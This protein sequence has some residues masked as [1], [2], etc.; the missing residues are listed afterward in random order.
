VYLGFYSLYKTLRHITTYLCKGRFNVAIGGAFV[1]YSLGLG[2]KTLE[3]KIL[4]VKPKK[5]KPKNYFN[6]Y[7]T[8]FHRQNFNMII[9][10]HYIY[11]I[12]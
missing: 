1:H 5:L 8:N 6:P 12:Y 7:I 11:V 9:M 10:N 3:L 2:P 4:N